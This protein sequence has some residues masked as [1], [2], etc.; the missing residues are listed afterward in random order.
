VAET[1]RPSP[2]SYWR[3]ALLSQLVSG[4]LDQQLTSSKSTNHIL[5]QD[6]S[7]SLTAVSPGQEERASSPV[8]RA[9]KDEL[10]ALGVLAPICI[11]K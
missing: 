9:L 1:F 11:S 8:K 5:K 6:T 7:C 4:S 2:S 3:D 10:M